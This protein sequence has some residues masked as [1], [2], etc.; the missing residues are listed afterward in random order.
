M[1]YYGQNKIIKSLKQLIEFDMK[2][3]FNS[4]MNTVQLANEFKN[5]LPQKD[6][7]RRS[8]KSRDKSTVSHS[9]KISYISGDKVVQLVE[10]IYR[11]QEAYYNMWDVRQNGPQTCNKKDIQIVRQV[12]ETCQKYLKIDAVRYDPLHLLHVNVIWG[13]IKDTPKIVKEL[14]ELKLT[15]NMNIE[16]ELWMLDQRLEGSTP[17]RI[18]GSSQFFKTPPMHLSSCL[19]RRNNSFLGESSFTDFRD[20]CK[21]SVNDISVASILHNLDKLS[22]MNSIRTV[23]KRNVK[24]ARAGGTLNVRQQAAEQLEQL[25]VIMRNFM[26]MGLSKIG[27]IEKEVK[28]CLAKNM[29]LFDKFPEATVRQMG[30]RLKQAVQQSAVLACISHPVARKADFVVYVMKFGNNRVVQDAIKYLDKKISKMIDF[31]QT[32]SSVLEETSIFVELVMH[33]PSDRALLRADQLEFFQKVLNARLMQEK[34]RIVNICKH[35]PEGSVHKVAEEV[36]QLEQ[37]Y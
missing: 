27:A 32:K 23:I 18:R 33:L 8:S 37:C 11:V 28:L 7:D 29:L 25:K 17:E 5:I 26:L 12:L 3:M 35:R 6:R 31:D 24:E 15:H 34:D 30:A 21:G 14:C 2:E 16:D 36:F 9:N 1:Q 13:L 20:Y 22:N 4:N 19:S 10:L